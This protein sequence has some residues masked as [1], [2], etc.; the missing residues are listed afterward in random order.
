MFLFFLLVKLL[1]E[2]DN[3]INGGE[4]RGELRLNLLGLIF[5]KLELFLDFGGIAYKASEVD[6]LVVS[7]LSNMFDEFV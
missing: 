4:L 2:F 7:E 1:L 5:F 3:S 6:E